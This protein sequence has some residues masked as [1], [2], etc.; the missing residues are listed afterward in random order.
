MTF[1]ELQLRY[2]EQKIQLGV[3][4]NVVEAL[5]V[6]FECALMELEARVAFLER[7][8]KRSC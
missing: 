6:K 4:E 1:E 3:V 8:N 2:G 5:T 7:V